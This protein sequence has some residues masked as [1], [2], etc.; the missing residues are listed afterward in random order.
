[1]TDFLAFTVIGVVTGA[2]YAVAASGLVVTYATSNVF[3][4]AHGAVGMVMAFLYWELSQFMP[5]GLALL[6][7]VLVA[8]PLLGALI[9]KT[10]MRALA[11][12]PTTVSVVVTVALMVAL[13]GLARTLW[14][15]AARPLQPFFPGR[16]VTMG[17]VFVTTHDLFTFGVALVVA[18]ALFV[19]LN[20]TRTGVAMRAVVDNRDLVA[21]FG[22][23]PMRLGQLSWALGSSLAALSGILLAPV[24]QL[25]YL[26]L[27]LLVVNAYAAAMVGRLKSLPMTFAGAL[28]L[29]LLTAYA[30]GYLPASGAFRGVRASLPTLFLFAVLLVLRQTRLRVGRVSGTKMVPVPSF[31][32]ALKW[33]VATVVVTLLVGLPLPTVNVSRLSMSFVLGIIM[34]SLVLLTGYAGQ[35]SLAQLTF[36]GIGAVIVARAGG[37]SPL[38]FLVAA[39]VAGLVGAVVALPALRLSGLE[40][41]LST[42]AFAVLVDKIFFESSW[43]FGIAGTTEVTRPALF[44]VTLASEQAFLAVTVICF[45]LVGWGV[46]A[47]RRGRFG[48]LLLAMRDSPAAC[49]TLGLNLTAAKVQVFAL[50]SAIAGLGG[51]LLAAQ[52]RIVG[53]PD[54]TMFSGMPILLLAVIGGIT[55]VTGAFIGGIS[56][57]LTFPLLS[58]YVP[59]FHEV[60]FLLIGLAAVKVARDPNGF[61]SQTFEHGRHLRALVLH[62]LAKARGGPAAAQP[63]APGDAHGGAHPGS[64]SAREVPVG[65]P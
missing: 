49:G 53:A 31:A 27:T 47:I 43:G 19:L 20:R 34:L 41:A 8:A 52:Q 37:G 60:E 50:S 29:G 18:G 57:A 10:M 22:A 4:M 45:V 16:G 21:L 44:G 15:P 61:A 64:D 26:A 3:N 14:P 32:R 48:R 51:A 23:R 2:V 40:L 36:A 13:I 9:E 58:E 28:G 7:V 56:L 6:L 59:Y 63:G 33:G 30:I 65:A 38:V 12:A 42:L 17:N 1:M 24:L 62:L 11:D 35:L 39:L 5:V 25:D 55:S 54:F 46:L